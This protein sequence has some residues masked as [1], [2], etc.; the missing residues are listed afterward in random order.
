MTSLLKLSHGPAAAFHYFVAGKIVAYSLVVLTD[1]FAVTNR[2]FDG[3][4]TYAWSD[5]SPRPKCLNPDFTLAERIRQRYFWSASLH[6]R[7][8]NVSGQK[9]RAT[10]TGTVDTWPDHRQASLD[11]YAAGAREVD[12]DLHVSNSFGIL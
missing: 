1:F 2:T 7:D 9:G 12:N 3:F 8:V 11:A 4:Q 6:N 10:S 5:T